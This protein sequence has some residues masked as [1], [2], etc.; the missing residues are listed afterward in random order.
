[1]PARPLSISLLIA[2]STNEQIPIFEMKKR[3]EKTTQTI[4]I[5]G[6]T[7]FDIFIDNVVDKR[8][9]TDI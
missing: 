8:T 2:W 5:A 7:A 1:M 3:E 4:S 6:E 9:D